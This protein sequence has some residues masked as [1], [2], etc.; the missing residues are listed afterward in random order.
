MRNYIFCQANRTKKLLSG[1]I[2]LLVTSASFQVSA[3][4]LALPEAPNQGVKLEQKDIEARGQLK[5]MVEKIMEDPEASEMIVQ[6]GQDRTIFCNVC[7]G[8]DGMAQRPGVPN[9]ASQNPVYLLDQIQRF[10][11][12]RRYDSTM[13]SLASNFTD[14]E[15][16]M[17]ALYY[18]MMEVQPEEIRDTKQWAQGKK[19]YDVA[20]AQ[21]HG[22]NGRGDKGYARLAS[23]KPDY[24][25]KMLK[26]FRNSTGRRANPWMTVVATSLSDEEMAAVAA[27]VSTLQ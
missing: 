14:D 7:H 19:V 18:S 4:P 12:G 6:T 20:C 17:L 2:F 1:L 22:E 27:Y 16:V 23:Q 9:L 26:E 3:K 25:V 24:V 5:A 21:C 13:T 10:A 11:D 8:K 15:K